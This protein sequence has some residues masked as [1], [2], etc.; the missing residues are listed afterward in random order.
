MW[1]L[2]HQWGAVLLVDSIICLRRISTSAPYRHDTCPLHHACVLALHLSCICSAHH[3]IANHSLPSSVGLSPVQDALGFWTCLHHLLTL[4]VSSNIYRSMHKLPVGWQ[5]VAFH[6]DIVAN[7]HPSLSACQS[8]NMTSMTSGQPVNSL[9]FILHWFSYQSPFVKIVCPCRQNQ[10]LMAQEFHGYFIHHIHSSDNATICFGHAKPSLRMELESSLSRTL[11][12]TPGRYVGT[13]FNKA[14][15]P[16]FH[17]EPLLLST[18]L[19]IFMSFAFPYCG[20]W[21]VPFTTMPLI[22]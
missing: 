17:A 14:H 20:A 4:I 9:F 16:N 2:T 21:Y 13:L 7:A 22:S 8:L 1:L 18:V 15:A 3:Y 10:R 19:A 5:L 6:F 12:A 11:R